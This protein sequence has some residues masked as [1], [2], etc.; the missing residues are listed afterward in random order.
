MGLNLQTIF[1]E[2]G[3]IKRLH[4]EFSDVTLFCEDG[5]QIEAHKIICAGCKSLYLGVAQT[6]EVQ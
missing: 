6:E 5:P 3:H 2:Q 4:E 1:T